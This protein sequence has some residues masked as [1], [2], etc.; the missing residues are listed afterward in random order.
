MLDLNQL[1]K[2]QMNPFTK[3]SK[4]WMLI[5]AKKNNK[6]NTMTAAWGGFG[7]LW[8]KNVAFIFI[9][10]QRYTKEFI[11]ASDELSLSFYDEQYRADLSYLGKISGKNENKIEKCNLHPAYYHSVPYFIEANT[12]LFCKKL[13]C[14]QLQPSSFYENSI[15]MKNY[16]ENDYH[17]MYIVEIYDLLSKK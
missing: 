17:Y 6:I 4:Q 3:L 11:D 2:L 8:N 13:Y 5:T 16:P 1:E 12:V 7:Y 15:S 10:P 9:R 14:Q